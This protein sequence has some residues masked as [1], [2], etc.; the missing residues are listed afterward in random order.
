M[1][2][3]LSYEK[4]LAIAARLFEALRSFYQGSRIVVL[5]D[6][7]GLRRTQRLGRADRD[8]RISHQ[9]ARLGR[10]GLSVDK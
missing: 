8:T 6:P 2:Q 7:R 5:S 1:G 10:C 4:R 9:R 3:K